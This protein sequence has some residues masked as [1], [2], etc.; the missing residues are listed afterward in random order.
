M[1]VVG[2]RTHPPANGTPAA[3]HDRTHDDQRFDPVGGSQLLIS[4][5]KASQPPPMWVEREHFH[6]DCAICAQI[7]HSKNVLARQRP[8]Q[9]RMACRTTAI[10]MKER[11]L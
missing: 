3:T 7:H 4:S 9:S 10:V 2:S 8:T 6:H 11:P 1:G 5:E